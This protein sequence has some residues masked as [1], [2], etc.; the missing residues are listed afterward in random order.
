MK[1]IKF[2]DVTGSACKK[3]GAETPAIECVTGCLPGEH[4]AGL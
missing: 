2:T 4:P 1:K 3:A